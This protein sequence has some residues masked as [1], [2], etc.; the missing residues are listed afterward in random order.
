LLH[1][2]EYLREMCLGFEKVFSFFQ[3]TSL[4]PIVTEY[5]PKKRAARTELADLVLTK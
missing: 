1:F 2:E 3:A 5:D 4:R